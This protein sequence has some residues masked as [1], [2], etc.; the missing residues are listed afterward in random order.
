MFNNNLGILNNKK[1][2]KRIKTSF[3]FYPIIIVV[4]KKQI[5]HSKKRESVSENDSFSL[6]EHSNE[7]NYS[8]IN[9]IFFDRIEFICITH[10]R[11]KMYNRIRFGPVLWW[12]CII[13]SKSQSFIIFFYLSGEINGINRIITSMIYA[14]YFTSK[15]R[16]T[17][18]LLL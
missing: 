16:S 4:F 7:H 13:N 15:W 8:R 5:V 12:M 9:K 18:F 2:Y 10:V 14:N 17:F 11:L 6:N 3:K 1:T